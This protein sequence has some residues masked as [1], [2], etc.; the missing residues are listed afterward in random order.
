MFYNLCQN[1]NPVALHLT[2]LHSEWPKLKGVLAILSAIGLNGLVQLAS[3]IA[4]FSM[5]G[6][7]GLDGL[8]YI[9]FALLVC[10]VHISEL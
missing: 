9:F 1:V 4:C 6:I 5:L 8:L 2:L 10:E 3:I 7:N